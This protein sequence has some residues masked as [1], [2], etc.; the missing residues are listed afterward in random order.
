MNPCEKSQS[1]N[2]EI[3]KELEICF[4]IIWW[5]KISLLPILKFYWTKWRK[6]YKLGVFVVSSLAYFLYK[7]RLK[8]KLGLCL[9]KFN[10]MQRNQLHFTTAQRFQPTAFK[11]D[12]C[13]ELFILPQYALRWNV[14][15]DIYF[16]NNGF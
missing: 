10:E 5:I 15:R 6:V 13:L 11:I 7:R 4:K 1:Y 12:T 9:F 3:S 16:W 8:K 2:F 14:Y